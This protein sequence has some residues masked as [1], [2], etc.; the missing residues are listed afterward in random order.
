MRLWDLHCKSMVVTGRN[1]TLQEASD[2]PPSKSTLYLLIIWE[3]LLGAIGC[4]WYR[5]VVWRGG[6]SEVVCV[7][8]SVG[9]TLI[10]VPVPSSPRSVN[11]RS[12]YRSTHARSIVMRIP[13]DGVQ[14]RGNGP[15][16]Q[17]HSGLSAVQCRASDDLGS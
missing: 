13:N 9:W 7:G 15:F 6:G 8:M 5:T 3:R 1:Q 12:V 14:G 4:S 2:P 11:F 17:F 16:L 10:L